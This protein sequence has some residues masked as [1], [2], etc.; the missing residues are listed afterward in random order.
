[1]I[2]TRTNQLN[3]GREDNQSRELITQ[4]GEACAEYFVEFPLEEEEQQQ[5]LKQRNIPK[6]WEEELANKMMVYLSIK[7]RREENYP[8]LLTNEEENYG[9]EQSKMKRGR[10]ECSNNNVNTEEAAL[11]K[12]NQDM[13][14]S[15]SEAE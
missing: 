7:R 9:E 15:T 5:E 4:K 3:I 10:I 2:R 1:M 6:A 11:E 12:V 14:N 13:E 8:L